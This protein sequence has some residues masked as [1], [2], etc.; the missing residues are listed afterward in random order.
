MLPYFQSTLSS[1]H[2]DRD[3][4]RS[5]DRS[6]AGGGSAQRR[7]VSSPPRPGH[8][9][10]GRNRVD[11]GTNLRQTTTRRDD[12]SA[13]TSAAATG[14]NAFPALRPGGSPSNAAAAGTK[15]RPGSQTGDATTRK[16]SSST[17]GGA[18]SGGAPGSPG[19]RP[20]AGQRVELKG[21][22]K[23]AG[24][25]G[26]TDSPSGPK[27]GSSAKD[28]VSKIEA[29]KDEALTTKGGPAPG[30]GAPGKVANPPVGGE[31]KAAG[32]GLPDA[33]AAAAAD[34]TQSVTDPKTGNVIKIVSDAAVK[35]QKAAPAS[36]SA[37]GEDAAMSIKVI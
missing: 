35:G 25:K 34:T 16:T 26:G 8:E 22:V 21:S 20:G 19:S 33:N 32:D 5:V 15:A 14:G 27:A 9:E 17:A 10:T 37:V 7:G 11:F 29:K 31:K 3:S 13:T 30:T 36:S 2:R 12:D 1:S 18:G 24:G 4:D 28:V 6:T 23:T